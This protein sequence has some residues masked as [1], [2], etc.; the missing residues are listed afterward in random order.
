MM[1]LSLK[2]RYQPG[3]LLAT[4]LMV[5][6]LPCGIATSRAW[7]QET[8]NGSQA[9]EA[10]SIFDQGILLAPQA[11]RYAAAQLTPSIVVIESFGGSTVSQGRMSGLR[12]QGEGNTTGVVL[13]SDG[14]IVTSTFNF[15]QQP[16]VV[17]VLTSDGERH[18]ARLAGRD[19][20]R[21]IC[22][23]KIEG[24]KDLPVPR[25]LDAD[26]VQ[27]GQW[28]I[29][30]G[31]GYGDDTP[32][33]S[34]GIISAKGR[35]SGRAL[36]TD[37]NISPANYGGPLIDIEGRVMGI[38]VPLN[39][40]APGPA[41]GVEWYD[42]GIGFAIPISTSE[43]WLSEL[44]EGQDLEF[45]FLG[46]NVKNHEGQVTVEGVSEKSPAEEAGVAQEDQILQ[47]NGVKIKDTAQLGVELRR[48][49]AGDT[50]QLELQRGTEMLSVEVILGQSP[51]S[52][53]EIPPVQ[54]TPVQPEA[55]DR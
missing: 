47:L 16:P 22:L 28:A 23:L 51:S 1:E 9:A 36:Q 50:V 53:P 37:A 24:V 15:M 2:S 39:P 44:K 14:W 17:T 45:G 20:T 52:T 48:Y 42:S 29:T 11:F 55:P 35:G 18:V 30:V 43:K 27:I 41:A 21:N 49:L 26:K 7:A 10:H 3:L 5:A 38:C 13:T 46:L 32:A 33:L 54:I 40:T 6:E 31:V 19:Q 4:L 8:D 34:T 25:W 12:S